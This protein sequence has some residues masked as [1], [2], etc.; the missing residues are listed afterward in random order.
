VS[1]DQRLADL[2]EFA[3][4][5]IEHTEP[6]EGGVRAPPYVPV[7]T[8]VEYAVALVLLVLTAPL[9]IALA[10]LAKLGSPGPAL[11][12]QTRL[13]RNGRQ[14]LMHKIRTMPQNAEVDTGPVWASHNHTRVT[15]I[16]QFFRDTHLDELPQLW[17]VLRGEMS[18]VGPRPE[19][20]ELAARL[21]RA[22]PHYTERLVMRPGITGLAQVQLPAD[23]DVED[24]RHKLAYDLYYV[25]RCGPLLDL[26]IVLATFCHVL[27]L[28]F[29]RTGKLLVRSSSDA[30]E[31]GIVGPPDVRAHHPGARTA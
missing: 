14:F 18:L 22:I 8:V 23:R 12:H 21:Q 27:G 30:I 3:Q 25:R 17:N 24:V 28:C 16:G 13:G 11:Y 10:A 19:R 4:D 15:R 31:G 29:D 20:P 6:N 5:L 2:A 9:Q 1:Q 26:R 7:K